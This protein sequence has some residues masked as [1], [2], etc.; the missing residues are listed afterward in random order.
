MDEE[1]YRHICNVKTIY[2]DKKGFFEDYIEHM[3]D[4]VGEEWIFKTFRSPQTDQD[5]I[6]NC[7]ANKDLSSA[8]ESV[9]TNVQEIYRAK[10]ESVA[11]Q[12]KNEA[13]I[14]EEAGNFTTSMILINQALVRAPKGSNVYIESLK[15]RTILSIKMKHY[16]DALHDTHLCLKEKLTPEQIIEGT[17]LYFQDGKPP[18]ISCSLEIQQS[19]LAGRFMTAK[20]NISSGETLVIEEPYASCLLPEKLGT[21][22]QNCLKRPLMT[23]HVPVLLK[24]EEA[25]RFMTAKENISSGE[26]LVIEEPYASCLLPEK[27]GTNCQNCLKRLPFTPIPCNECSTSVFCSVDCQKVALST[28]HRYECKFMDLLIGSGISILSLTALRIVTQSSVEYFRNYDQPSHPFYKIYSLESH[29][30]RRPAKDFYHRTLTCLFLLFILRK[31]GYFSQSNKANED[32]HVLNEDEAL[33]AQ[34]L[35]KSLQ[36]LQFNA[37]E[38]YETLFKT[39][40]HFP[41]AKINYVGVGIQ[42]L[43]KK[44]VCFSFSSPIWDHITGSRLISWRPDR[45]SWARNSARCTALTLL[46]EHDDSLLLTG[47]DDGSLSVYRNYASHEHRLVT[48]FQALTDTSFVNKSLSTVLNEDEALIAQILLKSLQVL[49]FNAHEVYETLFKTKHHFPNAKINYVGVGIYPTVSLF[50]HDCY[51]AVTRYFNGKNIIVKALRPLKPK[52]V[53]A[54]NYGLVFS[55]KHLIDRQKVLS[56]RYWFECK[57]RACVENWPLMESLEKY[58]I[59]IR[60][61]NDNC[62][63]II[64]TVKKLEPSAKKVEKK[65]ESCNSTSDL[66]EIKTKLSELNEMFYRGIEQ[67]NTSC[68]REA[69]ESLTKFSDQIHELVVPPYKLASL[70]HEALRNC[71]SLAGN[72]W[73]IPENYSQIK[74]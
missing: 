29:E 7:F 47:Y 61:S 36:V 39:K 53:V 26:T 16:A 46:N 74:S 19:D 2:S 28:Y 1:K 12:R 34:I 45:G 14:Y 23:F 8:L 15:T 56:A 30:K 40:H 44:G 60:C 51:P 33:I 66:T 57:C 6:N 24:L 13:K 64:A 52:E 21:N 62:G 25:G 72:K 4:V 42:Y 22:C 68:F 43:E 71:W 20:E 69:V 55:R 5:R 67:M 27:L 65:C 48:S 41:N 70:A 73:V 58:P 54:E 38:V 37:H 35:L 31:A 59:R 3:T 50:N 63:Q 17:D 49:Q 11:L 18:K 10:S 9:C 32:S